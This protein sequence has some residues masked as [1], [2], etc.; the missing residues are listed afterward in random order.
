MTYSLK[1][2][3]EA[4]S[5]C[6]RIAGDLDYET[7]GDLVEAASQLLARQNPVSDLHLDFSELRFLDSAALS[8]LLMLQRRASQAGVALHLDHRP[9]FLDRVLQVTGL[10]DHFDLTRSD[11]ETGDPSLLGQASSGKSGAR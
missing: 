4:R 2:S 3:T 9:Q 11:A 6:V 10:F 8:G 7:A 1:I 5:T